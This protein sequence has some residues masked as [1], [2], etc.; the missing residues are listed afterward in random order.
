MLDNTMMDKG[1]GQME[2]I[3]DKEMPQKNKRRRW[4]WFILPALAIALAIF[5][6]FQT[7]QNANTDKGSDIEIATH[8]SASIQSEKGP[9]SYTHLTLPTICSV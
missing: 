8:I 7:N 5:S 6:F 1:W 9:V 3:L 4:L 2:Q